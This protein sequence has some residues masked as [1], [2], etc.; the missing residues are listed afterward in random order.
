[1]MLTLTNRPQ[2]SRLLTEPTPKRN[3]IWRCPQCDSEIILHVRVSE[4]P[5]CHNLQS[6]S[7]IR[8]EMIKIRIVNKPE[9]Q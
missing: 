1:M 9:E 2:G 6:H 3:D 4:P 8:V 7:N 5:V